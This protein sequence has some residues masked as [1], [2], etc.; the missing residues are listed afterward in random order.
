MIGLS[1]VAREQEPLIYD[2]YNEDD[3]WEN[4][5]GDW[6]EE[7]LW[8]VLLGLGITGSLAVILLLVTLL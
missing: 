7:T 2:P 8:L 5:Y 3:R 1:F 6:T 4:A